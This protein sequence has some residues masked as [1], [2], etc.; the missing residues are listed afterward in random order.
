M[1]SS[2]SAGA[3]I[4]GGLYLVEPLQQT[5]A[6]LFHLSFRTSNFRRRRPPP[7][8]KPPKNCCDDSLYCMYQHFFAPPLRKIPHS[9]SQHD[10]WLV[11]GV[12]HKNLTHLVGRN[13]CLWAVP[14]PRAL[15][16]ARRPSF[17]RASA[18]PPPWAWKPNAVNAEVSCLTLL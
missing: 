16:L 5:R 13:A 4:L 10:G 8:K 15:P 2:V 17:S 11:V 18:V 1:P 12:Y 3:L 14:T 7:P 9:S 6:V